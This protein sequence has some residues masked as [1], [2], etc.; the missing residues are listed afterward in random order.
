VKLSTVPEN[1][2]SPA[3]CGAIAPAGSSAWIVPLHGSPIT[4]MTNRSIIPE[5][6]GGL[7]RIPKHW[8]VLRRTSA[9]EIA[10]HAPPVAPQESSFG[11]TGA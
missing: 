1:L 10:E 9:S 11:V 5:A 3:S 2:H 6:E 4:E 8:V 7:M